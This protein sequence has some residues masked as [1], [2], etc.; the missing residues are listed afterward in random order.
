MRLWNSKISIELVYRSKRNVSEEIWIT[1]L[2]EQ[3]DCDIL[4][5]YLKGRDQG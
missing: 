4:E 3:L 1:R 5:R 2:V